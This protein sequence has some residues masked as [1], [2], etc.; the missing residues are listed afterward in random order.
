MDAG[1]E[2]IERLAEADVQAEVSSSPHAGIPLNK[3]RLKAWLIECY[4]K[5]SPDLPR[6]AATNGFI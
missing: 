2:E 5:M 4:Q 6:K 1:D 3:A